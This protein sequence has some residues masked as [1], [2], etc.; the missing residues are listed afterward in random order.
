VKQLWESK[1]KPVNA[2]SRTEVSDITAFPTA[3][4]VLSNPSKP[5]NQF[6][7]YLQRHK[8]KALAQLNDA[9]ASDDE[10]IRYIKEKIEWTDDPIAWWLESSQKHKYP[11]LSK[12]AINILSIP[13]MS[14]DVERLFSSC[15]LTL[16]D[17][18][19]RIGIELLEALECLKSWFKIKEFNILEPM[20]IGNSFNGSDSE[21]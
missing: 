4:S 17:R 20:G 5:V 10:Y 21:V 19:N 15:G 8:A 1:Y 7:E 16:E 9:T 14:A 6:A 13:C 2:V 18:R 11:H 3:S 12:M